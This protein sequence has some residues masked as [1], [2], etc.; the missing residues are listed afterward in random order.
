MSVPLGQNGITHR[1]STMYTFIIIL[2]HYYVTLNQSS[3]SC[4]QACFSIF[5]CWWQWS[6]RVSKSWWLGH[7]GEQMSISHSSFKNIFSLHLYFI[8][9][10]PGMLW[11]INYCE[12][13]TLLQMIYDKFKRKTG[14]HFSILVLAT[15][16]LQTFVFLLLHISVN[17]LNEHVLHSLDGIFIHMRTTRPSHA[18][19]N[20]PNLKKLLFPL[21]TSSNTSLILWRKSRETAWSSVC[22]PMQ[23]FVALIFPHLSSVVTSLGR[24]RPYGERMGFRVED[25]FV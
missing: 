14:L 25:I 2:R 19:S 4:Y 8:S 20:S 12:A 17:S 23:N 21:E 13:P 10:M 5:W 1:I 18:V 3:H 9:G 7:H 24:W 6:V 22:E 11:I 15:L 16:A